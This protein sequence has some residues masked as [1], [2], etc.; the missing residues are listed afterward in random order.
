[1]I[2]ECSSEPPEVNS[3]PCNEQ[4][5][6]P[7]QIFVLLPLFVFDLKRLSPLLSAKHHLFNYGQVSSVASH[8]PPPLFMHLLFTHRP[9]AA[10]LMLEKNI[11]RFVQQKIRKAGELPAIRGGKGG[12]NTCSI[13]PPRTCWD[14]EPGS[15]RPKENAADQL[16]ILYF[17]GRGTRWSVWVPSS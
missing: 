9:P 17:T 7:L 11:W 14:R 2:S 13:S 1:M 3:I 4:M 6:R 8:V 16:S 15:H 5:M 12:E 10:T